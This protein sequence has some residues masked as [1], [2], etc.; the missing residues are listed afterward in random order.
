MTQSGWG[1]ME[2]RAYW[3]TSLDTW[4]PAGGSGLEFL[5]GGAL[6][7]EVSL[8]GWAS[9]LHSLALLPVSSVSWLQGHT[10]SDFWFLLGQVGEPLGQ[11]TAK[12]ALKWVMKKC[13]C[14][15]VS[16]ASRPTWYIQ[17]TSGTSWC[18]RASIFFQR[19][20]P[21]MARWQNLWVKPPSRVGLSRKFG[22]QLRSAATIAYCL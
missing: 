13:V 14:G 17:H 21:E 5:R 15:Q 1:V 2:Q 9:M 11:G 22:Y 20:P 6:P 3:L 7:E 12:K 8:W 10:A 4:A 16:K 19:A 18:Q